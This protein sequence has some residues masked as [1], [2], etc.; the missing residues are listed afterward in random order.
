M[1]LMTLNMASPIRPPGSPS[2]FFFFA[3]LGSFHVQAGLPAIEV[4]GRRRDDVCGH[5]H[6]RWRVVPR[7]LALGQGVS[8]REEPRY[9][10]GLELGS[11]KRR[12]LQ[13]IAEGR[14]EVN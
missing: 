7:T 12:P 3:T 13:R 1:G 11:G 6:L 2:K 8:L 9:T 14:R 10:V 4:D 5:G